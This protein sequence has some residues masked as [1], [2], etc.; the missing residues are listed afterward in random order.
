LDRVQTEVIPQIPYTHW[1]LDRI[2]HPPKRK[3]KP[4]DYI[5]WVMLS[6]VILI[7]IMTPI[8][9]CRK[10]ENPGCMNRMGRVLCPT[11]S[12]TSEAVI[13]PPMK[14]LSLS[15]EDILKGTKFQETPG[16]L[17]MPTRFPTPSTSRDTPISS[18]EYLSEGTSTMSNS[19]IGKERENIEKGSNHGKLN[20]ESLISKSLDQLE[21][22]SREMRDTF[23]IVA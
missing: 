4:V 14:E 20:K 17:R 2:A 7:F 15:F 11:P 23:N 8:I 13:P 19:V 9:Y 5:K 21:A 22:M 12:S 3:R 16:L 1:E 10:K 18:R 6:A